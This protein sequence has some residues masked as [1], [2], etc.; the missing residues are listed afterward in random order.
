MARPFSLP[1]SCRHRTAFRMRQ[2]FNISTGNRKPERHLPRQK[3]G[4]G[5]LLVE[6]G[7]SLPLQL[8]LG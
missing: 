7:M 3:G 8:H 6:V 5:L 1:E 4:W 2:T